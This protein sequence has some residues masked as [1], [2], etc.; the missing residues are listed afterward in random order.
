MHTDFRTCPVRAGLRLAPVKSAAPPD[1]RKRP[2][3]PVWFQSPHYTLFPG[4]SKLNEFKRQSG[5]N[6]VSLYG[7][8]SN[9]PPKR[10][11]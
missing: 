9:L 4:A 3:K 7:Q 1:R 2:F 6:L 8:V 11:F 5:Q 10:G